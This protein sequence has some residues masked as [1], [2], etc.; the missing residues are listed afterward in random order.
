MCD[1]HN[2]DLN[3]QSCSLLKIINDKQIIIF[4]NSIL[5]YS[6]DMMSTHS[7]P[8]QYPLHIH[9]VP[10]P[11]PLHTSTIPAPYPL[12]IC[13]VP[14]LY[15]HCTE[16]PEPPEWLASYHH[17]Y[18]TNVHTFGSIHGYL[19]GF[20]RV[21]TQPLSLSLSLSCDYDI[22]QWLWQNL[23]IMTFFSGYDNF[24]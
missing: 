9:S 20:V 15:Q 13:S 24:Q 23:Q 6:Y 7:V 3:V 10:T 11:F 12:H 14:T 22:F 17:F 5:N 19:E 8:A 4:H 2:M 18:P 16:P 21:Y 1:I